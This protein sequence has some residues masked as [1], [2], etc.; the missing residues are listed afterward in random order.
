MGDL[1]TFVDEYI[2][3]YGLVNESDS[4]Y[5]YNNT[6][7]PRTTEILSAM[8]HEENLMSWS[9]WL[10]KYKREDY[11]KYLE[12]ASTI[13]NYVHNFIV[14][15][16]QYG[17]EHSKEEIMWYTMA[18]KVFNA[19]DSF[20]QWWISLNDSRKVEVI[21]QEKKLICP[22]FGGTLDLLLK[23]D[24]EEIWLIDFK[25]S[26]HPS[27]KYFLQL[28]SYLHMLKKYHSIEVDKCCILML[29]KNKVKH[30][31]LTVDLHKE[32]DFEFMKTCER[33]FLIL[34]EAYLARLKTECMYRDLLGLK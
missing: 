1:F 27:Y 16:I 19:F 7:V 8:L 29:N 14:D 18:E 6:K 34:V 15:Y 4:L 11:K 30:E 21:F 17:R 31:M 26:N 9:N 12:M 10:G 28:A 2:D 24:D 20:K 5:V 22:Y 23:L 32:K 13:G 33:E 25:S 3:Y